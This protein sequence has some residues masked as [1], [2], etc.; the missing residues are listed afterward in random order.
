MTDVMGRVLVVGAVLLVSIVVALLWK[1]REASPVQRIRNTGLSPGIYFFSSSSCAECGPVR[2]SL[3]DR[4]GEQRFVELSWESN[5]EIF[6]RLR[7]DAVPAT[8]M[9]TESGSGKLST[10]HIESMFW[11]LILE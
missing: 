2:S 6:E 4:L 10:G 7:V 3:I 5:P 8:L 11:S 1:R 9:V